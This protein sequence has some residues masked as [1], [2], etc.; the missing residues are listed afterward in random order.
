MQRFYNWQSLLS[1]FFRERK[2]MPFQWGTND[3]CIFAA[4]AVLVQ[5]G[6]DLAAEM[7]GTYAD[8]MAAARVLAPMGG[9]RGVAV[10]L[11]G[12]PLAPRMARV[13]DVC[14]AENMGRQLL[15][16][17]GGLVA[18]GPGETGTVRVPMQQVQEC[19]RI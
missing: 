4:D 7:R 13:G 10:G 3:C 12:E 5:T 17:C 14:L 16:V 2:Y 6:I 15:M 19:W 8:P 11:L 9:V 1:E 18:I